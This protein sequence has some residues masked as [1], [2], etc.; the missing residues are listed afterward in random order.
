MRD[1]E[2]DGVWRFNGYSAFVHTICGVYS[3]FAFAADDRGAGVR[4]GTRMKYASN[5]GFGCSRPV[6]ELC[7]AAS[8]AFDEA[9]GYTYPP[10][11]GRPVDAA[12]SA[13]AATPSAPISA[14]PAPLPTPEP[15]LSPTGEGEDVCYGELSYLAVEE[16]STVGQQL[17]TASSDR[18]K[19]ACTDTQECNSLTLCPQWSGCWMK[20]RRFDGGEDTRE[21]GECKTYFKRPCSSTVV[22]APSATTTPKPMPTPEPTVAP[23][24]APAGSSPTGGSWERHELNCYVGNGADHVLLPGAVGGGDSAHVPGLTLQRCREL[25]VSTSGC[26]A[27]TMSVSGG[28]CFGRRSVEIDRCAPGGAYFT[29]LHRV[30]VGPTPSTPAPSPLPTSPSP[31]AGAGGPFPITIQNTLPSSVSANPCVLYGGNSLKIFTPSGQQVVIPPGTSETLTDD[32]TSSGGLGVQINNWYWSF[33][34]PTAS[35]V[36]SSFGPKNPDNSGVNF[37]LGADCVAGA[38]ENPWQCCG[39]RTDFVSNV[40]VGGTRRVGAR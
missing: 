4:N 18:C 1:V 11:A 40:T 8:T 25:C 30:A 3:G 9:G 38:F 39:V 13:P 35:A 12:S 19:E 33:S 36:V 20:D 24:M 6:I 34:A 5:M 7:P 26:T 22:P 15:T 21:L 27:I 29:E 23:T 31:P 14:A 16:G 2:G 10:P 32:W 37:R 17:Y 28:D